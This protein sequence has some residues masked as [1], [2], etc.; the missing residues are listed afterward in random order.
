MGI[1]YFANRNRLRVLGHYQ[2]FSDESLFLPIC[3]FYPSL[4]LNIRCI[5]HRMLALCLVIRT[6]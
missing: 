1:I 2:Q 6:C 5:I 3:N 4:W